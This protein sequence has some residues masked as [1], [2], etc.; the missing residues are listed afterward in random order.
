MEQER[1]LVIDAHSD[2]LNDVL[3]QRTL[4]R[5]NV[6]EEDWLP[7][8]RKGGVDIRVAA[9]YSDVAY[10]PE[11]ALRRGLDLVAA[12]YEEIAESSS[13]MLCTTVADIKQAKESG[14]ISF[15]FGME[16]SEPL[17]R[18]IQLLRVFYL[19]GL[20]VLG[21]T[22]GLRNYAADPAFFSPTETGK[23][24]GLS[25]FGVRLVQE[26]N[27]LG[28]VI[29]VSHLNEP[30][31]WDVL[32]KTN[33]PVIASHSNCRA[34]FDHPRG[35]WDDQIKAIAENGGVIGINACAM[36]VNGSEN[37]TLNDLLNHLDHIVSTGG[38][39]SAGLGF[40]FADY[41]TKYMSED[42]R[43]RLPYIGPVQGLSGDA[44]VSKITEELV[45]RGY[46]DNDIELILG[47]NFLRVFEKV[48][49]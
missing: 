37:A 38:V 25:D 5:K 42:E 36:L 45:R 8:M 24:G 33:A 47:K 44:D 27:R 11:L 9:I 17:G 13:L 21:L 23:V 20:R 48:L 28:V 32:E 3:P 34:L 39:E 49:K 12:L 6:I 40:D 26:A 4:G 14:K 10:V 15:I 31:F 46:G 22:H 7:G 30:S 19:L 35:L 1:S 29:D 18:D 43:T 41:L 2:L 16:G